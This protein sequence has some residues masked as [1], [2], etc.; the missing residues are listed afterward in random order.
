MRDGVTTLKWSAQ[1]VRE[2]IA[3]STTAAKS[4]GE[5]AFARNRII[6]SPPCD[7]R[8]K[9]SSPKSLSIVSR[10]SPS[11]THRTRTALSEDPG[12]SSKPRRF[13]SP[14]CE[15]RERQDRESSHPQETS[16][17][18]KRI[19]PLRVQ[20]V[21]GVGKAGPDVWL[22]QVG[23]AG[24]NLLLTPTLSKQL[25]NQ[26]DGN[27]RTF[28]HWFAHQDARIDANSVLPVHDSTIAKKTALR[29]ISNAVA[30]LGR[31]RRPVPSEY[32]CETAALGCSLVL[33]PIWGTRYTVGE[34]CVSSH[35]P[36]CG[37]LSIR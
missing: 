2:F 35:G 7:P 30:S 15:G 29:R 24:E 12:A 6:P 17:S 4:S 14:P 28:D 34:Q 36:R 5:G 19:N 16:R 9:T 23:I 18:L 3:A 22:R 10:M 20:N 13:R 32:L 27:A 26:F 31:G 11:S 37:D 8:P 25:H 21:T 33:V 1:S